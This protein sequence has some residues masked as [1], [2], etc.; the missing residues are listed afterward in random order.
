MR[1]LLTYLFLLSCLFCKT[2]PST[3]YFRNIS[4]GN[5][6]SHNKINCIIQDKRGF[7]WIGTDDGLNRYDGNRFQSFRHDPSNPASLS[8]NMITDLLEDKNELLWISTA[9]GGL[10]RYDYRL[11]PKNQFRQYKHSPLDSLSIPVNIINALVEDKSGY[12]WLATSGHGVLRFDKQKEIFAEPIRRRSRTCLDLAIDHKGMIWAGKQGGGLT[13][14]DP[15][16]LKYEEDERYLNVYAKLPHMTVASLFRDSKNNMWLGSWDKVVYRVNPTDNKESVFQKTSDPYSFPGD[17]PLAFAEDKYQHI[18][19]GGRY[20]GLYFFHPATEKFF[21]YKHDPGKE[22]TLADNQVNCIYIDRSD[23]VWIGTNRGISIYDPAQQKFTQTFL[24]ELNYNRQTLYDFYMDE[25]DN[26]LIGCSDG[27]YIKNGRDG[28]LRHHTVVY[29]NEKLAVTKFFRD[30]D[31]V[32]Y[33]GTNVSVFILNKNLTVQALPNTEKDVVMKRIIE[34]RVVS[35]TTDTIEGHPVLLVSPYGHYLTYY[36]FTLKQWVSRLD[37]TRQ[38]VKNF[39]IKDNLIRKFFKAT[40]GKIW[41]ATAKAGLGEW[42]KN[43]L[44]SIQYYYNMPGR[45]SVIST[46]HIYDIKDDIKG[47]LWVSTYGGGLHYFNTNTKK[48]Q[49]ITASHNLAEGIQTDAAGNVWMIANGNLNKYDPYHKSYSTYQLPDLEK[50][51]GVKGYIYKDA[52]GKMYIAG[53]NYFIAFNPGSVSDLNTT[54][55]VHFTD[56]K[57]FNNSYSHL[58]FE[59]EI[60]LKYNENFFSVEYAAPGYQAGYPV[61][62]AHKLEGVDD[63]WIEDGIQ[64]AVNYTNLDAGEYEFKVRATVKPGVWGNEISS[65]SIRIN[66]PWWRTW[67]FFAI[68]AAFIS[69]LIYVMYRYRINELLK[70]QAI[71]NKIAQDLHDNVGSTLSSISVYSQV[72]KIYQQQNK[73]EPLQDTL[74]KISLTSSE[75]ISEMNDIVWA[76]NPRNDNMATILQRM[77]SFAR[78][79]LASQDVKFHFSY[80]LSVQHQHLEMTKRKNFYLIFKEAV[81][82]AMKYSGCKNIWV[83]IN[84]HHHQLAISVKDDGKGFD[85]KK[86][87]SMNTLSGNGVRNMEMRSKE[88]KGSC[89]IESGEGGTAILLQF[90]IP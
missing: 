34:S 87:K 76:I 82:N 25:S 90:P 36:D 38:I 7:T 47:N 19:I 61:Q 37:S 1:I 26:L 18:W 62:Y 72:A 28:S 52:K 56:F 51:G 58:L 66:P 9:D 24:P 70:R 27:L 86:V 69:L 21:Q 85:I 39:N 57:I 78:P 13:K 44:P 14:I 54:P 88:M 40:N 64:S 46:N 29:K 83:E 35:M 5:G 65:V 74:E 73:M 17:D 16:T 22:G 48:F 89:R 11:A 84:L 79:L 2:Q 63:D 77:E 31:D 8:G 67:W 71:R 53:N 80:D 41:M 68:V 50:T 23:I 33:I 4:T 20:N 45:D 42:I 12:L 43:S 3:L 55:V 30:A 75:M 10:T 32:L 59:K 6:L 49:H 60:K 81:N 15:Q